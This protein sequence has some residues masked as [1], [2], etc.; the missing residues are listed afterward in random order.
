MFKIGDIELKNRVVLAP[1]AGVC[2]SA[3]RL[4]VKEFGAGLVCA[5]MVSDKAILYNNAKISIRLMRNILILQFFRKCCIIAQSEGV[6]KSTLLCPPG[7]ELR[8]E[9]IWVRRGGSYLMPI[10]AGFVISRQ[11]RAVTINFGVYRLH[12]FWCYR[13]HHSQESKRRLF[14]RIVEQQSG[15]FLHVRFAVHAALGDSVSQQ[16]SG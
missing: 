13:A 8:L 4:T 1:M 15:E 2:N 11:G 7:P 5:E 10:I 3:F 14:P 16:K 6:Q 12:R 9:T